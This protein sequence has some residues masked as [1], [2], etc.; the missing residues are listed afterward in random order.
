MSS[1]KM[2]RSR[3]AGMIAAATLAC[4][5]S[6]GCETMTWIFDDWTVENL[7]ASHYENMEKQIAN[8]E[9]VNAESQPVDGM[10]GSTAEQIMHGYRQRQAQPPTVRG[11]S[12]I[13]IGTGASK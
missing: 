4:L 13:N 12:I 2:S 3:L 1:M 6:L 7:G 5:P 11:P 9:V 8:P 10:D